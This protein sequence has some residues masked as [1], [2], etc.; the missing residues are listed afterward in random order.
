[1]RRRW[2]ECGVGEGSTYHVVEC[3]REFLLSERCEQGEK[4]VT[5]LVP[6]AT[7][8]DPAIVIEIDFLNP[9]TPR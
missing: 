9:C 1:M 2:G 7:I 6:V 4:G 3:Y 5:H 8:L